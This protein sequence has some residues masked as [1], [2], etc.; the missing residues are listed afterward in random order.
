MGISKIS[1]SDGMILAVRFNARKEQ[2]K[3]ARRVSDD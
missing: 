2:G 3:D 1:R